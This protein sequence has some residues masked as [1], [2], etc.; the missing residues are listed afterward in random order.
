MRALALVAVLGVIAS[1]L[2]ST[3]STAWQVM[4]VRE[5]IYE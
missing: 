3:H 4:R 1:V 2:L 5:L